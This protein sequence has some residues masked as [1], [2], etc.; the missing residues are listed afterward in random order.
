[1]AL[2]K[3]IEESQPLIKEYN[4]IKIDQLNHRIYENRIN[5]N[6][7]KMNNQNNQ[8]NQNNNNLDNIFNIYKK[9]LFD[10]GIKTQEE[11]N[12][13]KYQKYIET[14]KNNKNIPHI[15]PKL[16]THFNNSTFEERLQNPASNGPL[17]KKYKIAQL[18][19]F[20]EQ[21][22]KRQEMKNIV[23]EDLDGLFNFN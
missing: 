1:M 5:N 17:S 18:K 23:K 10:I 19:Q 21:N 11:I 22:K 7:N 3:E 9:N 6:Q 8:N 14:N 20:F 12:T 16:F 15:N 13:E 4:D 2:L